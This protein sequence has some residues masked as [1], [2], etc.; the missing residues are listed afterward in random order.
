MQFAAAQIEA[1]ADCILLADH[2]T[3]DLCGPRMY[4]QYL[5]PLHR[6]LAAEIKAPVILHICGNTRDRIG[7]IAGTGLAVLPLGH[8]DGQPGRGPPP[9]RRTAGADGRRQ[10]LQAAAGHAGR[11]RRRCRCRGRGRHQRRRPRVSPFRWRRRW[12][13]YWRSCR[14]DARRLRLD[15]QAADESSFDRQSPSGFTAR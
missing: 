10:Q 11:D 7:M 1:G 2:A 14:S 3:R 6:R 5:V 13:T 8:E 12:R 9:G 4:E 15:H